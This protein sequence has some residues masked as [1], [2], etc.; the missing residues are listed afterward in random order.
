MSQSLWLNVHDFTNSCRLYEI[1]FISS[2]DKEAAAN[3]KLSTAWIVCE[4]AVLA[5]S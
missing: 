3:V 2:S 5:L 4:V 1:L